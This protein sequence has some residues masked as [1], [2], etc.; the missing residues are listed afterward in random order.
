[1]QRHWSAAVSS[2]TSRS[3]LKRPNKSHLYRRPCLAKRLRLVCDPQRLALAARIH[4]DGR[5]LELVSAAGHSPALVRLGWRWDGVVQVRLC[6]VKNR[7]VSDRNCVVATR[8]GEQR[9]E[10]DQSVT[11]D[12]RMAVRREL[13]SVGVDGRAYERKAKPVRAGVNP[14]A[15]GR[16][17]VVALMV[18]DGMV[19]SLNEATKETRQCWRVRRAYR[20]RTWLAGVRAS[21]VAVKRVMTV[22]RRERRKVEVRRAER[23]KRTPTRV[24]ARAHRRW[25]QPSAIGSGDTERLTDALGDEAKRRSLSRE[26][27]PTGKPDAGEPPVRFGGRGSGPVRSPYPYPGPTAPFRL[28]MTGLPCV[29]TWLTHFMHRPSVGDMG[30]QPA[31]HRG[32]EG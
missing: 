18:G 29:T 20:P 14:L 22:E 10:N 17:P 1:M 3:T 16:S 24:P 31:V 8:G 23:R 21:V 27:P 26:H 9:N 28:R 30:S 5:G 6:A 2:S 11:Q 12:C 19:G 7:A 13:D 4:T 25:N 15:A 32:D